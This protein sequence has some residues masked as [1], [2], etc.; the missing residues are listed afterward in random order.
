[1]SV[2]NHVHVG[3]YSD[4]YHSPH[5]VWHALRKAGIL[6]ACLSSTSIC[7]ELY[8][9]VK[10]EFFQLFALAGRENIK[11]ILW[12]TPRMIKKKWPLEYLFNSKIEWYGIKLHYIAHPQF[13][14]SNFLETNYILIAKRLGNVPV[15]LHTGEWDTCRAAVFQQIIVDNPDLTFVLAHGRPIHE[16]IFLMK[17]YPNVWTDTAFMPIEYVKKLKEE[18]LTARTMF[19]SD[20]PINRIYYPDLSTEE[21]L[22]ARIAE[23]KGIAPEILSNCVYDK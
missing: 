19:G 17:R 16:T 15:L 14:N 7:A 3:W 10:T 18:G 5:E 1:M 13:A 11:P 6:K 8:H 22:K 9:N 20:A 4:G 2:D 12:I 23:V 21:Y